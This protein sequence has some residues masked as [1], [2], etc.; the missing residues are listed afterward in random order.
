VDS[1]ILVVKWGATGIDTIQRALHS[2][3]AVYDKVIG[4]VLNKVDIDSLGRFDGDSGGYYNNK[5]YER[6]GYTE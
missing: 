5:L 1:Y 2:A 3:R 6:Y 4:V